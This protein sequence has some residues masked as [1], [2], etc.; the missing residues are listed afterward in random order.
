MLIVIEMGC[1]IPLIP[2]MS[3][4]ASPSDDTLQS[5]N[6]SPDISGFSYSRSFHLATQRKMTVM[7]DPIRRKQHFSPL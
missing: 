1:A 6:G 2:H 4:P 5:E 7:F 3:L